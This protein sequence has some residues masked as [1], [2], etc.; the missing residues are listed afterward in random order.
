VEEFTVVPT[1]IESVA[2]VVTR[3]APAI[4]RVLCHD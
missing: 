3:S 4:V 1:L 2:G